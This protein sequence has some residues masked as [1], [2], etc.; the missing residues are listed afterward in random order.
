MAVFSN[1][2]P[3]FNNTGEDLLITVTVTVDGT[4][5]GTPVNVTGWNGTFSLYATREAATPAYS[6]AFT[7][8]PPGTNGQLQATVP[9]ATTDTL[10]DRAYW[11]QFD[12]TDSGGEATVAAGNCTFYR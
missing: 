1:I 6:V 7:V 3:F 5:T 10:V 2:G 8:P 11:F 9:H 12:R 4:A